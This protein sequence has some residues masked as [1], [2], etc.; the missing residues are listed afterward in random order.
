MSRVYVA[1]VLASVAFG[2]AKADTEKPIAPTESARN[3]SGVVL[4]VRPREVCEA[5][6][7]PGARCLPVGDLLG[8][9]HRLAN[10]SGLLWLLGTAGLTGTEPVLVAGT[11]ARDRDF[12]AGLLYL[13]GQ[14]SVQV[15][16][17]PIAKA[18]LDL[19]TGEARGNTREAV[20]LAS[21][22]GDALVLRTDVLQTV[23]SQSPA[24]LL[25]ARNEGEYWGKTIRAARGGHIPG[26]QPVSLKAIGNRPETA[27][28]HSHTGTSDTPIVYGHDALE[29]LAA[30]ARLRAAGYEARVYVEGW[31]D[32]AADGALPADAATHLDR[33]SENKQTPVQGID[34]AGRSAWTNLNLALAGF[35]ILAI[36]FFVGR[37]TATAKG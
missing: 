9:H 37:R 20:Y 12:L 19:K 17:R 26:A 14:A 22:R 35:G 4:D 6:S 31:A 2:Q 30:F 27:P 33:L 29:G 18:G 7:L 15:L 24:L 25:D 32:W 8:P 16:T 11:P 10:I 36:G 1:L 34:K 3:F 13:A 21:M 28:T 5:A 23:R